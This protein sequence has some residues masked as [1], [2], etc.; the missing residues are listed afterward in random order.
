MHRVPVVKDGRLVKIISQSSII[1]VITKHIS[2]IL[3]DN[4]N[5]LTIGGMDLGS[6]DVLKVTK[7]TSVI[8]TFR[9]MDKKQRSGIAIVDYTGRIVGTTTGK[10]LGLFVKNPTLAA[11]T[12]SIF[13]YLK[14][15]RMQQIE[16]RAPL[17]TVFPTD[18]ITRAVALLSSTRVHRI[19]I[20]NNESDFVPIGVLSITDL[21][22]FLVL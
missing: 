6:K 4:S 8:E 20:V 7:E 9:K 12:T 15:V 5:D 13:D 18:K 3:F 17:I 14:Y 10:D 11:L 21:L 19:F 22:K 16:I 1:R 2:G